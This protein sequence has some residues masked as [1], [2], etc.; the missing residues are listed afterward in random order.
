MTVKIR[1]FIDNDL[2]TVLKLL[3]DDGKGGY[4]FY[5]YNEDRLRAWMQEGRLKILMAE[6]NGKASGSAAYSHG[7]WGEEIEWLIV[8]EEPKRK[9][10]EN[11]L[12]NKV[13]KFV[14]GGT[15]FTVVDAGSDEIDE[16]V[17]RGYRLEGG[18]YHLV[19]KLDSETPTPDVPEGTVVRSLRKEEEENSSK[20]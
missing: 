9:F 17:E 16:W 8:N 20:Q 12:L 7:H 6:D 18:L 2:Q 1:R 11:M 15:V 3:N 13:E 10:A 19:A 5:P 4:E 14:H